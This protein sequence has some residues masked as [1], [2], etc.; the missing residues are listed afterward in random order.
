M[1]RRADRRREALVS[2]S[3]GGVGCGVEWRREGEGEQPVGAGIPCVPKSNLVLA[4]FPS[5]R[6]NPLLTSLVLLALF[7]EPCD[8]LPPF[9]KVTCPCGSI[10][11]DISGE[12][13]SGERPCR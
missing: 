3:S 4:S 7:G 1:L 5:Q 8:L 9:G 6:I 13:E 12:T 2:G 11:A 10:A